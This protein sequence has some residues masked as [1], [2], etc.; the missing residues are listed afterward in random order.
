MATESQVPSQP[1]DRPPF[2]WD[3]DEQRLAVESLPGRPLLLIGGFG[4]GKTSAAIIHLI[5]LASTFPNYKVAVLRKVYKDLELSTR[6]SFDQWI[7]PK[8]L[9]KPPTK[10]E[11]VFDN[12]S[13][14][15]FHHLDLGANLN[16]FLKGL[17]IN[18]CLVD[19]AEEIDEDAFKILYGRLGRWRAASV[20]QWVI[21]SRPGPWPWVERGTSR[22]VPPIACILTANPT[23]E[24]D[25]ELHWLWQRFHPDSPAYREKWCGLGYRQ[26]VFSS[27]KSRHLSEANLQN[28][29][30]GDDDFIARY[31][32]GRW[33]K[34]KGHIWTMHNDSLLK[35]DPELLSRIRNR[36]RLGRV[37][38]HGDSAYTCCLWY[39]VDEMGDIF[40]FQEYY[41]QSP[42]K[43]GKEHGVA[44]H[45]RSITAMSLGME[46]SI[47]INLADPQIFKR[48]RGVDAYTRKNERWS[49]ADE[50][51]DNQLIR[52]PTAISW[53]EADNNE[54]LSRERIKQ[55]LS[56]DLRHRHPITGEWGAPHMYFVLPGSDHPFGIVKAIR[57]I[58]EAKRE[59]VG[60]G[61]DGKP[62]FGREREKA[63]DH[64]LDCVRY[65]ANSKPAPKATATPP[66]V[67]RAEMKQPG[68]VTL[69]LPPI[70]TAYHPRKAERW[71]SSGG[72]Y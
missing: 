30:E 63:E 54:M 38:D 33:V 17:E 25:P 32:E 21:A 20:P 28:L 27:R 16:T 71:R 11:I 9:K 39:G 2:E 67:M 58:R 4:S 24:G 35:P 47:S 7:D 69:M 41:Q 59:K 48:T 15:I 50:Y 1:P 66:S 10:E 13:S 40:F 34:S 46:R 64:A 37:L 5:A 57:Q 51:A 60:E 43:D 31:V 42:D 36:M 70:E 49:V 14:F 26:I 62:I 6:P 3:S 29:L 45:R 72:G 56:I 68:V 23:G 52:E 55:Y 53:N 19:Q 8:R 44:E 22:P 12:G 61:P 18:A 65:V